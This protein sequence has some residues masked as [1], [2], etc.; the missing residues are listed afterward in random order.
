MRDAMILTIGRAAIA[1]DIG[2]RLT[3]ARHI[4]MP[5]LPMPIAADE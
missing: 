2:I 5:S 3:D 1:D 4:F